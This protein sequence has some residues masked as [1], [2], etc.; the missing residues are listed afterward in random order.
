[1]EWSGLPPL[2]MLRAFEAAARL[3]GFSAAGRELN[4]THAAISQ[5]VRALEERL[6]AELMRRQGRRVT[7]TEDG[8]LLADGLSAGLATI[9]MSLE[10]FEARNRARPVVVTLTPAFASGWL[11]PRLGAFRRAH[12]EIELVLDPTAR[13]VD[14]GAAEVDLGVRFGNGDWEGLDSRR[15]LASTM[16]IVAAPSLLAE[17]GR[18]VETPADLRDLPWIQEVGV[19][20]WPVWLRN[21]G[22]PVEAGAMTAHLPG[23]MALDALREGQGVGMTAKVIVE[24][25]LAAGRLHALFET[26]SEPEIGYYLVRRPGPMRPGVQTLHDWLVAQTREES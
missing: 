2:S 11:T 26:G 20:E 14:F 25:D 8:R 9:K 17:L 4:V 18:P 12:P 24:K 3:G 15:L 19:D 7:L 16:V 10:A 13:L 5:H 21:N 6:G 1:M 22:V 23:Y